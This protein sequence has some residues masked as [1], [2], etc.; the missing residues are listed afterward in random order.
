MDAKL[1]FWC[2]ALANMGLVV[3]LVA[4][5]VRAIRANRVEAHRRAMLWAGLCVVAFLVAYLAKVALLGGEDRSLWS[6]AARVN[7][8]VHESFVAAMLL[9]GIAALVLG[10]RLAKTR[11]VTQQPGDPSADAQTLARHRLAGRIAAIG[12]LFGFL[13]AIGILAGMIARA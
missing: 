2:W 5:G 10:R 4:R 8:Y 6:P 1:L 13:T 11:R 12:A 3:V 7:L 9:A